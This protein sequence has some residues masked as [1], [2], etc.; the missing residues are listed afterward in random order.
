MAFNDSKKLSNII[1]I[2]HCLKIIAERNMSDTIFQRQQINI[3]REELM[4]SMISI[5]LLNPALACHYSIFYQYLSRNEKKMADLQKIQENKLLFE[6]IKIDRL[7]KIQ[8]NLSILEELESDD[9]NNQDS[10]D[11]RILFNA[12]SHKFISS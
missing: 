11:Q 4:E 5:S 6:K 1:A 7:T 10:I 2:Q 3:L 8:D 9:D 12:V